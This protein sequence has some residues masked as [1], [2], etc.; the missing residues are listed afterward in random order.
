M[1]LFFSTKNSIDIFL[2]E[3]VHDKTYNKTYVTSKDSEQPVYQPSM[4]SMFISLWI[5]QKL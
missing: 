1:A 5:A 3:P 4:A 2:F